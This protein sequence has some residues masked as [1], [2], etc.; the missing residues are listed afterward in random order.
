MYKLTKITPLSD[1]GNKDNTMINHAI[2][3]AKKSEFPSFKLG[4]CLKNKGRVTY[5]G[6]NKYRGLTGGVHYFTLHAEMNALYKSLKM[7]N[8]Y[9]FNP[10]NAK[11]YKASVIYVVR[12]MAPKTR[13]NNLL[14]GMS[15]PCEHCQT[16]LKM[17]NVTKIKY[18]DIIDGVS[19]LCEMKIDT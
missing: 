13:K 16:F 3:A 15:K 19:V 12:L 10:K 6:E 2:D 4:A 18:T 1:L 14:L 7:N 9:K 5:V 17:Y 11:N 8:T